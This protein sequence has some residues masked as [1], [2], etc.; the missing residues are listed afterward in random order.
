MR[1]DSI[2]VSAK[3]Q[4]GLVAQPALRGV[5]RDR[6]LDEA[7]DRFL[8]KGFS[9]TS[10]QEIADAVGMTKPALY[11]HFRDKN[12]LF[13]SVIARGGPT[14]AFTLNSFLKPTRTVDRLG[15][16]T[17]VTYDSQGN[18]LTIKHAVGTAVQ[19]TWTY[20]FNSK[21]QVPKVT[22]PNGKA[23]DH[24]YNATG[25]LTSI[26]EPP[27]VTG[28]SRA[29]K[30]FEFSPAGRLTASIDASGRRVNR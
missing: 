16:I 19:A 11:Y 22:D 3:A 12:E 21:G 24:A 15:R 28:G 26:T 10:M 30:T 7:R 8:A 1:T 14:A 4:I 13:L 29:V 23:T 17:D 25:F 9:A 5:G 20:V 2:V 27:D 6:I 18:P